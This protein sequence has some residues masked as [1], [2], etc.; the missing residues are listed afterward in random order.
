RKQPASPPRPEILPKQHPF[1]VPAVA[2]D[3]EGA[4]QNGLLRF[5]RSPERHPEGRFASAQILAAANQDPSSDP[6]ERETESRVAQPDLDAASG[7]VRRSVS[8]PGQD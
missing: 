6:C 7:I 8:V 2:P 5:P 3:R 1:A 4:P